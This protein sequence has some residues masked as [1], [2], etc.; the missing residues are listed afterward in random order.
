MIFL[1]ADKGIR[2]CREVVYYL[3][4]PTFPYKIL[5]NIGIL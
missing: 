5:E 2:K 3:T 1:R 4:I